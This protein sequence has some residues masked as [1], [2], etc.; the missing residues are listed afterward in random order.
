MKSATTW[1]EGFKTWIV[2]NA[3]ELA[4]IAL[5]IGGGVFTAMVMVQ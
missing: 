1:N 4:W 3:T 5:V 2:L